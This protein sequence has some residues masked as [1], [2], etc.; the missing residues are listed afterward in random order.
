MQDDRTEF[1][2]I[3]ED[4]EVIAESEKDRLVFRFRWTARHFFGFQKSAQ[5]NYPSPVPHSSEQ[6]SGGGRLQ[7]QG[8]PRRDL[9]YVHSVQRRLRFRG[10]SNG[11]VECGRQL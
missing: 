10:Q 6:G 9:P 7:Q 11:I 5:G 8:H 4:E 2:A 3:S 1:P